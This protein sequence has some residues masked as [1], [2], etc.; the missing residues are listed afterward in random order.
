MASA[1][2]KA[3][4]IGKGIKR[5]EMPYL[6]NGR[7]ATLKETVSCVREMVDSERVEPLCEHTLDE[8]GICVD[9]GEVVYNGPEAYDILGDR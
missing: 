1:W 4:E 2:D 7:P 6:I 5:V 8:D 9:C 3:I